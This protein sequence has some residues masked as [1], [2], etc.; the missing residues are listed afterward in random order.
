MLILIL[1]LIIG[2]VLVYISK[3]NFTPVT[4]NL[5]AYIFSDIPLFYVIVGSLLIG[6][7]LSYLVYLVR[8]ISTS[9]TLHGKNKEIKKDENKILELTRRIHQLEL[10]NKKLNHL[11]Q[12]VPEDPSTL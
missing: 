6:L 9:F 4:L 12:N 8:A 1:F 5:G 2:S 11:S 10:E 3:F 7:V